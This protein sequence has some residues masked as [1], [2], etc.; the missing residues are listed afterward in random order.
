MSTSMSRSGQ[1]SGN[2]VRV[3]ATVLCAILL[4]ECISAASISVGGN[5]GWILNGQK[6]ANLKLKSKDVA[7]FKYRAGE[8][9][10]VQVSKADYDSCSSRKPIKTYSSGNDKVSLKPGTYYFICGIGN[11]C[12]NNMKVT[13]S[14]SK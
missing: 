11:H 8:H 10:V 4:V 7:V 3:L 6:Y 14:V 5:S 9:N 1:G 2:A 13:I 12:K